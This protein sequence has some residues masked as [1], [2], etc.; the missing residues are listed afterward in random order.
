MRGGPM[1]PD[2]DAF[3]TEVQARLAAQIPEL[4]RAEGADDLVSALQT[5]GNVPAALTLIARV[6]A[7]G[8]LVHNS[9][10]QREVVELSIVVV[11]ESFRSRS[12]A[13]SSNAGVRRAVKIALSDW[14]PSNAHLKLRF[15]TERFFARSATRVAY[16]MRFATAFISDYTE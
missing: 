4:R 16:E 11:T 14:L 2:Y 10:R 6:E 8:R 5:S 12:G 1:T 3:E 7:E 13:R 9:P 15:M